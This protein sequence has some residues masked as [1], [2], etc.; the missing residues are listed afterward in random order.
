MRAAIYLL[1]CDERNLPIV[2]TL[3]TEEEYN[4][5]KEL[6]CAAQQAKSERYVYRPGILF[7]CINGGTAF[8]LS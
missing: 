6:R 5:E 8:N 1:E 7:A 4:D 2:I 3:V